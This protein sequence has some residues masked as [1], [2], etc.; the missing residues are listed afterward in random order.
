MFRSLLKEKKNLLKNYTKYIPTIG[1]EIHAQI[2]TNTK[3]FSGASTSFAR[4]PNSQTALFDI[5]IPGTLPVLNKFCVEQAIKTSIALHGKVNE[6]S[7]F[8]RKHY[9]Y[10]DL[11]LGYQITQQ[12]KPLMKDGNLTIDLPD[13]TTKDIRI[14]RLQI[15]QDSGKS[16]HDQDDTSSLVDFNR[17]G[18]PL[19]EIITDPSISS[20]VEA[21][22]FMKTLQFLLRHIGTCDGNF[23]EGSLRC[24]VNVSIRPENETEF[25]TRCEIKNVT[26]IQAVIKSIEIEIKRQTNLLKKGLKIEQ[27]TRLY[28]AK[29]NKTTLLRTKENTPDYKFTPDPDL[30]PLKISNE[31]IEKIKSELP[32]LPNEIISKLINNY[33]LSKYDSNVLLFSNSIKYFEECLNNNY[34][35]AK[36]VS[37]WISSELLGLLKK[38][39][40][41]IFDSPITP[42][43]LG[44][45]VDSIESDKISSKIAK[46]LLNKMFEGD[47]RN[48]FEIIKA[49][50]LEQI[51]DEKLLSNLCEN[52]LNENEDQIYRYTVKKNQRVFGFF[53]GEVLR[54]TE[55]KG[56]PTLIT[57]ILQEKLKNRGN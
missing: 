1:L 12:F 39:E 37:N 47:T 26:G 21:E 19:M 51:T 46:Y 11:P 15:E 17:C 18:M 20:T 55:D 29:N 57:K 56:S 10:P 27:E 38:N 53:V 6:I 32:E 33:Q 4:T 41:S 30:P 8:D 3:L 50:N 45:I 5:S 36:K 22:F 13:G 9:F 31:W 23:E 7:Q 2:K 35:N 42:D 14:Q 54:R 40:I 52:V 48:A 28:D 34:R 44:T 25:G 49:E 43:Q 16:I 24:D